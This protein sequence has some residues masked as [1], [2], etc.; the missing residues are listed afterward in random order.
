MTTTIVGSTRLE[1]TDWIPGSVRPMREG[2]YERRVSDGTYSC[3]D[4]AAWNRDSDSPAEA[5]GSRTTSRDQNASWRGLTER[6]ELPC[7]T[8]NGHGIVDRGYDEASSRD[9]IDECPDC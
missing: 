3:W 2:V 1:V 9:L 6:S 4:G 7:A 5:A 8:C